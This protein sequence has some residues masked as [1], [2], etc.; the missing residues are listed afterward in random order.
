MFIGSLRSSVQDLPGFLADSSKVNELVSKKTP[1]LGTA[2]P[3]A[4]SSRAAS[5]RFSSPILLNLDPDV[6]VITGD[7]STP[8]KLKRHSWHRVPVLIAAETARFDSAAAFNEA[9]CNSGT[10]GQIRHVDIMP[11]ALAHAMRLGKYGA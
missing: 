8:A 7:H 11:L 3:S 6:L 10:L 9:S 5:R 2:Y 4:S 1:N